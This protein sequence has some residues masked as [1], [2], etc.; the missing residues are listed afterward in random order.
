MFFFGNCEFQGCFYT[1]KSY[2]A[3]ELLY[4]LIIQYR[5]FYTTTLKVSH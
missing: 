2:A 5:Q 4:V 3:L 1:I